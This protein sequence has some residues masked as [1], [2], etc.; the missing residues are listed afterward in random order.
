MKTDV[1]CLVC[2]LRQAIQVSRICC[3]PGTTQIAVVK[4]VSSLV[5]EMDIL[6]SPP[7]NALQVYGTIA[8]ITGVDD[9]YRKL[10]KEGNEQ[11]IK[12]LPA[13]RKEVKASGEPLL[14]AV[15]FA[16]A[17]NIIDYGA[18]DNPDI[19]RALD[20]SRV[21]APVVDDSL[22]FFKRV[23]E[24]KRNSKVLYLADNCGEI[25]YDSLL[26]ECLFEYGFDITV[27]VK[28]GPIINDALAGD[29]LVAG[30]GKYARIITNGTRCPGTVL[31]L[32]STEF[33][34]YFNDADLI[35]SKGQGNFESLSE[36]DRDIFFLLTVKCAIA[37]R[38]MADLTGTK[39][40]Y[41]PGKG[42][43][44]VFYSRTVGR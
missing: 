34:G 39:L 36:V 25:V 16:I 28:D 14:A 18:I 10:K 29:A 35:I 22:L 7:E 2:F 32:C 44:A 37:A 23:K 26:I 27:V 20:R 43:M 3:C 5:S 8:A 42:E 40:E 6:K 24:L 15:R 9:P 17:G 4:A 31:D 41:L 13:L 12:L 21:F 30:L 1:E 38:H 11:A 33:V 19:D